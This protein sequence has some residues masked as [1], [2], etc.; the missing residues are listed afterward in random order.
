[1]IEDYAEGYLKGFDIGWDHGMRIGKR[2]NLLRGWLIGVMTC[3]AFDISI[4]LI[5]WYFR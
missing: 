3:C 1:M 2:N 4:T 5:F